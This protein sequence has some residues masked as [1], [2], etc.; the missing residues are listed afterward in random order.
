MRKL[1][2]AILTI[3]S[4]FF[5]VLINYSTPAYKVGKI[6][7]AEVKRVDNSDNVKDEYGSKTLL[8]RDVYYVYLQGD[9][10]DPLVL[11]N[12]DTKLGFPMYFKFDSANEQ[13]KI[14]GFQDN[15]SRVWV[16]YYGW[17]ITILSVFPNLIESKETS[18][19]EPPLP[20]LAF[21]MYALWFLL[22]AFVATKILKKSN[23][24]GDIVDARSI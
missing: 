4:L 2:I 23:N 14:R 12:E 16:K 8:T 11:R 15:K 7:G 5:L 17:R 10:G 22:T 6:T 3:V 21:V 1:K 19:I 13:A 20:I 18:D 24:E 9:D